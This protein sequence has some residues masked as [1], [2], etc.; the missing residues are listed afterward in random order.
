[1]RLILSFARKV[2]NRM[3]RVWH[4][5]QGRIAIFRSG[6]R[7]YGRVHAGPQ[8]RLRCSD[9]GFLS[10]GAEVSL[11]RFSEVTAKYGSLVIGSGTFI[12]PF[13]VVCARHSIIIGKDCLIAEHVTIRDHDHEFGHGLVTADAGFDV[14][15]VVIGDNVWIGAKVTV[16][17]GVTIGRNSVIGAN[18]VVTRDIPADS[19]AV[20]NP[21]RVVRTMAPGS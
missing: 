15:E 3:Q 20:G 1:M 7:Y 6:V 14:A 8:V 12:G 2:L 9:G 17:K 4:A 19:V 10:L 16:T 18:A 21:A 11:D 5:F 13:S